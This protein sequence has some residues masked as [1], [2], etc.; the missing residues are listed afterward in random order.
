MKKLKSIIL[1]FV[2]IQTQISAQERAD[3]IHNRP[4]INKEVVRRS[5]LPLSLITT[6]VVISGSHFEKNIKKKLRGGEGVIDYA[7]PVDDLM[8][9]VPI[10]QIYI[11]DV[12]GIKAKNHWFDQTKYLIISNVITAALTHGAKFAINKERPNGSSYAFPSGHSSFSFANATVLYE[13][14]HD[15]APG[16]ACSG[17]VLTSMVGSLRV[18]NNKHWVSDVLAGAGLG[19]LVTRLVYSWEPLKN[20]NPCKKMKDVTFIPSFDSSGG[21]FTFVYRF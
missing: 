20:W 10:A 11:A 7:I 16:F 19:I 9:Y 12:L 21:S 15:T 4:L 18:I 1:F 8:Q 6:G 2:L 5:V 3:S 14:F 17:Y 13:E